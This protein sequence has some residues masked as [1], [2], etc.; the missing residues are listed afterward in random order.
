VKYQ[1]FEK[2]QS[3]THFQGANELLPENSRGMNLLCTL[4]EVAAKTMKEM[5]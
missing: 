4:Q 1:K 2:R 3:I 5:L